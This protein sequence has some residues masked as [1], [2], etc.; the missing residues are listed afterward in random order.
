MISKQHLKNAL[1]GWFVLVFLLGTTAC[2]HSVFSYNGK[3]VKPG[4]RIPIKPGGP[5]QSKWKEEDLTL[6][7]RYLRKADSLNI[8][9][10][11]TF[12]N[13]IVYN[14]RDFSDFFLTVYFTDADG[15]INGE[16][17]MTSA[18]MGQ[19]IGKL[20]F[21]KQVKLP[22]GTENMVFGY[23]GE[24]V[25]RSGGSSFGLNGAIAWEFWKSPMR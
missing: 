5:H 2:Q 23:R 20:S 7:Y 14:Y 10:K 22:P 9:G 4:I 16:K 18:G 13:H 19:P 25:D 1:T 3:M 15:R 8:S 17:S 6:D 21:N 24:V 12:T 11:I